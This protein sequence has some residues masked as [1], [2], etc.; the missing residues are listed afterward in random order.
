MSLKDHQNEFW[1]A[2][3]SLFFMYYFISESDHLEVKAFLRRLETSDETFLT[4]FHLLFRH[5]WTQV[6]C[7]ISAVYFIWLTPKCFACMWLNPCQAQL[8]FGCLIYF[9]FYI[10]IF[11][12]FPDVSFTVAQGQI[13]VLIKK[14]LF[15]V[16]K[17]FSQQTSYETNRLKFQRAACLEGLWSLLYTVWSWRMYAYPL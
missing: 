11:W 12:L 14:G 4:R 10:Y 2:W 3:S 1:P 9:F 13:S 8:L 6:L 5:C 16:L 7:L 17:V 15:S